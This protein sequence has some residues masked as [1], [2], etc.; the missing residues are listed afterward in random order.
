MDHQINGIALPNE[1]G[2]FG[3]YGGQFIPPHLKAAMDDI[4]VAYEQ[5]RVTEEFQTELAELFAHTMLVVQ[6]LC[7]MQNGYLNSWAG[8]RSI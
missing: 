1:A 6:V 2:F 5:I 3:N 7:F 4:K 8:H